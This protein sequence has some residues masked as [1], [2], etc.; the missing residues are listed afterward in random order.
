[1]SAVKEGSPLE[2]VLAEGAEVHALYGRGVPKKFLDCSQLNG[3]E[4]VEM[5]VKTTKTKVRR[6]QCQ[7][8]RQRQ[9]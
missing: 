1:M 4:V 7:R 6:R 5:L 8:Q 2:E 9:R 3:R